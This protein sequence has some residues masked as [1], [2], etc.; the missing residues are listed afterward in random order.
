MEYVW[1]SNK[2]N[3]KSMDSLSYINDISMQLLING[4]K[5]NKK[6]KKQKLR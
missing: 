4:G 3:V 5:K 6:K 2:D 1:T